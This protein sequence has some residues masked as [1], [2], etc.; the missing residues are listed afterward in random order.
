MGAVLRLDCKLFLAFRIKA[1][2]PGRE[3]DRAF[4]VLF[5]LESDRVS[6]ETLLVSVRNMNATKISQINTRPLMDLKL[7]GTVFLMCQLVQYRCR[8]S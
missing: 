1:Q 4:E 7:T 8:P 5:D 2:E 3:E 6:D